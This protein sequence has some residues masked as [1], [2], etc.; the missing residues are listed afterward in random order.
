MVPRR[1]NAR[2][3]ARTLRRFPLV[4]RPLVAKGGVGRLQKWAGYLRSE[5]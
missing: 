1:R 4:D 5:R 3:L 2:R